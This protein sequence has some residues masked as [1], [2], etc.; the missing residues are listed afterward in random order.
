MFD[1]VFFNNFVSKKT[2]RLGPKKARRPSERV[3][4]FLWT[5]RSSPRSKNGWFDQSRRYSARPNKPSTILYS[6][7]IVNSFI[8]C[9]GPPI[10]SPSPSLNHS[11][12]GVDA[13]LLLE[14]LREVGART[15]P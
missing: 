9:G 15:A 13:P 7:V 11:I 4:W 2:Y 10:A 12:R 1:P 6:P 8:S 14:G 5:P 3:S